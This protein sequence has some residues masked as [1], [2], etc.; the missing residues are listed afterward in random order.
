MQEENTAQE[1]PLKNLIMSL[2]QGALS[3]LRWTQMV[4]MILAWSFALIMMFGTLLVG[5]QEQAFAL[6]TYL[7]DSFPGLTARVQ[8]LVEASDSSSE[9]GEFDLEGLMAWMGKG[10]A[11][12]AG[13]LMVV[14]WLWHQVR[15]TPPPPPASWRQKLRVPLIAS[16]VVVGLIM[17]GGLA[18][19]AERGMATYGPMLLYFVLLF[20]AS[21]YSISISHVIGKV[22]DSLDSA[23]PSPTGLSQKPGQA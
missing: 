5:F 8:S 6:L 3:Y 10:W 2:V 7:T 13:I 18:A 9:S 15:K 17:T 4:P 14:S 11:I 20:G 22:Q 12:F 23:P 1:S 19:G 21:A 16:A